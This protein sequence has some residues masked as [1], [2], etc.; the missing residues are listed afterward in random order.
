MPNLN[1][2]LVDHQIITDENIDNLKQINPSL[3]IIR[4]DA[5]KL[6]KGKKR[7]K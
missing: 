1:Y 4:N 5:L 3:K 6:V 7:K 2:L